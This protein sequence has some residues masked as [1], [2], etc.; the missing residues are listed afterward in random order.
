MA[1][2]FDISSDPVQR[3]LG[4]II[5]CLEE[6][7][8]LVLLVDGMWERLDYTLHFFKIDTFSHLVYSGQAGAPGYIEGW[9][10]TPWAALMDLLRDGVE[11]KKHWA[12]EA[13]QRREERKAARAKRARAR[14]RG[15]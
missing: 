9:G 8:A 13:T 6:R 4:Q 1:Y 5:N 14:K 3:G 10:I 15:K 7:Q 11:A 2:Y 12:E